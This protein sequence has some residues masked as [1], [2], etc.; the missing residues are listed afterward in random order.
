MFKD[1]AVKKESRED[2]LKRTERERK[3]REEK[4]IQSMQVVS[5]TRTY[6]GFISRKKLLLEVATNFDRKISD[7][8]KL[9]DV[10]MT[11]Q[12]KSFTPPPK[13]LLELMIGERGCI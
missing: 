10:L 11:L 1:D 9:Q 6:R 3:E 8:I 7:I 2:F 4:R 13:V 12:R 5:I